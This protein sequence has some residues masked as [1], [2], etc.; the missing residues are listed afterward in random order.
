MSSQASPTS[1]GILT[2]TT[3]LVVREGKTVQKMLGTKKTSALKCHAKTS[4]SKWC[5]DEDD[6][7]DENDVEDD[8]LLLLESMIGDEPTVDEEEEVVVDV[9]V[10]VVIVEDDEC[11]SSSGAVTVIVVFENQCPRGCCKCGRS[12]ELLAMWMTPSVRRR[13]VTR[14]CPMLVLRV[15]TTLTVSAGPSGF[16]KQSCRARYWYNRRF[17][18]CAMQS[19]IVNFFRLTSTIL[20]TC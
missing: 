14:K 16:R 13:S 7:D 3:Y 11:V 10:V 19:S 12:E 5:V 15:M 18:C 2:L 4:S 6:E 9:V 17:H 20:L 8:Q 1:F